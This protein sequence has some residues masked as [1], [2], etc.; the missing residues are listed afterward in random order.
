MPRKLDFRY[1][2]SRVRNLRSSIEKNTWPLFC[3]EVLKLYLTVYLYEA[4]STNTKYVWV[5][6]GDRVFKVRFSDHE[7]H[8]NMPSSDFYVGHGNTTKE[9]IEAVKAWSGL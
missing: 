8:P 1:V 2:K 9:A 7:P 5:I 3:R 4:R 6:A